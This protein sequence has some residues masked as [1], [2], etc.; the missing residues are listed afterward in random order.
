MCVKEQEVTYIQLNVLRINRCHILRRDYPLEHDIEGM[1]EG[2]RELGGR[3]GRRRKQL[4]DSFKKEED[5][6]T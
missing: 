6:C 4:M 1:V 3:R 2:R 5:S